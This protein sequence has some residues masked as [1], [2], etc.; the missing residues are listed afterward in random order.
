VPLRKLVGVD[1]CGYLADVI[2]RIVQRHPNSRLDE[3]LALRL[4]GHAR[5]KGRGLRTT[6]TRGSEMDA[7]GVGLA[8][9]TAHVDSAYVGNNSNSVPLG[10]LGTLL[11]IIAGGEP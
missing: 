10:E 1:P 11:P 9:L 4:P 6:A 3:P 7:T 5:P 8:G 2:T